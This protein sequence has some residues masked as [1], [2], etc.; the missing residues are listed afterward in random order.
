MKKTKK[1][2]RNAVCW[3]SFANP[4]WNRGDRVR[5]LRLCSRVSKAL[6]QRPPVIK[7]LEQV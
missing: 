2:R 5:F 1:M 6:C 4:G 7:D 3:A